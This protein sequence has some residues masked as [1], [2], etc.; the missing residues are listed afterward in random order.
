M[1]PNLGK[2]VEC[3]AG[4]KTPGN[5]IIDQR[6]VLDEHD[7][8]ASCSPV[9]GGGCSATQ[10]ECEWYRVCKPHALSEE[11]IGR[12]RLCARHADWLSDALM[13]AA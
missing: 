10:P 2:C 1:T 12:L 9:T 8:C 6:K 4:S 5:G 13:G 7:R 3:G 11:E